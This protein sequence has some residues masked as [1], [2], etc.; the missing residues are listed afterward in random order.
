MRYVVDAS[1]LGASGLQ[2]EALKCADTLHAIETLG[3][4][5]VGNE[6][7]WTEWQ[8]VLSRIGRDWVVRMVKRGRY[9]QLTDAPDEDLRAAAQAIPKRLSQAAAAAIIKDVHLIELA[10]QAD[11][12]IVTLDKKLEAYVSKCLPTHPSVLDLVWIGA[13]PER[14]APSEQS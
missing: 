5:V 4:G 9:E 12:H 2:D 3:H 14:I 1:I 6:L 10:N 7:L 13:E 11:R 8:A